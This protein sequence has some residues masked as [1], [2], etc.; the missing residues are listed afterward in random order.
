MSPLGGVYEAKSLSVT[1]DGALMCLIPQI[2]LD[3]QV[4]VT[5]WVGARPDPGVF[6]FVAFLGGDPA[7]PVWLGVS[8]G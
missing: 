6:G 4:Q 7:W 3:T 2:Y 5:R 1:N 8:G